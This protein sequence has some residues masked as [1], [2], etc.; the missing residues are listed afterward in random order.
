M[1]RVARLISRQ[2]TDSMI[3]EERA[4]RVARPILLVL[5][6]AAL[7]VLLQRWVGDTTIYSRD[8]AETR[9]EFHNAILKNKPPRG[10]TW[11]M[12]GLN[13][14]NNR[15]FTVYLAEVVHRSTGLSIGKIYFLIESVALFSIFIL[16]FF[17]CR[18]WVSE[19][20]C[21][22]GMLFFGC[23]AVL[24]YHLHVFQ[25]WDR[26]SLLSWM[27]LIML[28]WDN[29]LLLL[30]LLLPIVMTIKWDVGVLPVLY[31]LT[32]ASRENWRRV[33]LA[34]GGLGALALA[35]SVALNMAF[36]GRFDVNAPT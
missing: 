34:T 26:L 17:F 13:G 31:G 23:V 15:V 28:I 7:T 21:V 36:P 24:T 27:V 3:H 29:H 19:P 1:P 35:T 4:A 30:A 6:A 10:S 22:I 32:H 25:P 12:T 9:V 11:Q 16:L 8:A 33:A 2:H 18:R 20:Y 14:L 5:V